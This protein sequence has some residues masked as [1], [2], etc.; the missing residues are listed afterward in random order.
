MD[1]NFRNGLSEFCTEFSRLELGLSE[2]SEPFSVSYILIH[3]HS[4]KTL[5]W[6]Q[7]GPRGGA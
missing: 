6:W 2:Y 3:M 4:M 7:R 5:N 1:A